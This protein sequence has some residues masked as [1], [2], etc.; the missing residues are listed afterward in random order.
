MFHGAKQIS[1][2]LTVQ[3]FFCC[4]LFNFIVKT[5]NAEADRDNQAQSKITHFQQKKSDP[6]SALSAGGKKKDF[7]F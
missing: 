3:M 4:F 7:C 6:N 2:L 5:V 1:H